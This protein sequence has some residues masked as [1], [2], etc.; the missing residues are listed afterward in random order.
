MG[1]TPFPG[2]E[3]S[4]MGLLAIDATT[5]SV[6]W[7]YPTFRVSMGAGVLATGSGLVFLAT[8][9][10]EFDRTRSQDWKIPLAFPDRAATS[11]PRP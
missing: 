8:G 1:G 9:R 11:L 7:E 2:S 4:K 3:S 5:G 10:R 6:M